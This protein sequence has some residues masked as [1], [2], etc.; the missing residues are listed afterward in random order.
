MAGRSG[1]SDEELIRT[2]RLIKLLY[3][4]SK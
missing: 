2:V 3:Q 1:D 4:S